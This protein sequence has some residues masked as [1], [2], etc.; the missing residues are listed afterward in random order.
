MIEA[1]N[2]IGFDGQAL[3]D[4]VT[5]HRIRGTAN[6][7]DGPLLVQRGIHCQID[8]GHTTLADLGKDLV[9]LADQ[10]V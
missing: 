4:Q 8:G 3:N 7:L 9:P 6:F 1:L 2:H 5:L 10:C